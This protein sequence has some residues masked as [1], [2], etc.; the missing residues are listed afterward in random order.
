M[1]NVA[2][3]TESLYYVYKEAMEKGIRSEF[4]FEIVLEDLSTAEVILNDK[5]TKFKI[6]AHSPNLYII[7][8]PKLFVDMLNSFTADKLED[9]ILVGKHT[10]RVN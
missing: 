10:F 4:K 6:P 3:V 5:G 1:E 9:F 8:S 7:T 2:K